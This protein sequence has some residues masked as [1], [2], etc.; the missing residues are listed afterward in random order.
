M[1]ILNDFLAICEKPWYLTTHGTQTDHSSAYQSDKHYSSENDETIASIFLTIAATKGDAQA[2]IQTDEKLNMPNV[3]TY[4]QLYNQ[5]QMLA[6]RLVVDYEVKVGDVI[7]QCM[8][9]GFDMVIG[10]LATFMVGGVYCPLNPTD[11]EERISTLIEITHTR[12]VLL[13]SSTE[14]VLQHVNKPIDKLTFNHKDCKSTCI[15]FTDNKVKIF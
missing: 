15:Y 10:L 5:V 11:P 14:H 2:I 13:H 4:S 1:Y 6:H 8:E 3:L 9:R 7:C 12:L